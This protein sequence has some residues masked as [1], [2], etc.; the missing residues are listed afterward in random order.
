M[1]PTDEPHPLVDQPVGGVLLGWV[2]GVFLII[3]K[4]SLIPKFIGYIEYLDLLDLSE[5]T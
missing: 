3:L 4:Y 1:G 5:G 2:W